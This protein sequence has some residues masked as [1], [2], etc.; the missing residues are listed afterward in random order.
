MNLD[1]ME[2]KSEKAIHSVGGS[3][4][5]CRLCCFQAS[6]PDNFRLVCANHIYHLNRT[7]NTREF[8]FLSGSGIVL[9]VY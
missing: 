4:L 7:L 6:R 3:A 1:A 2:V 9:A 5:N 8:S